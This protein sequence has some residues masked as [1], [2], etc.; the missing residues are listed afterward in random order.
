MRRFVIFPYHPTLIV[1]GPRGGVTVDRLRKR[2]LVAELLQGA[3]VIPDG[4][5]RRD[6]GRGE[7]YRALG[8]SST[9]HKNDER[10]E[11]GK[12]RHGRRALEPWLLRTS[13]RPFLMCGFVPP[14]ESP[15]LYRPGR[16]ALL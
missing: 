11:K 8:Q 15:S 12:L 6:C 2:V 10:E 14:L 16:T 13:Q 1:V 4:W 3:F 9:S 5:R 7:S